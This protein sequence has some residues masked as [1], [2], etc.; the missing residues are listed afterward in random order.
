M[1]IEQPWDVRHIYT[2]ADLDFERYLNHLHE[3]LRKSKQAGWIQ[4]LHDCPV[5]QDSGI[6][7]TVQAS[8]WAELVI[9]DL[10]GWTVEQ[11]PWLGTTT[12]LPGMLLRDLPTDSWSASAIFLTG[13]RGGTP[14]FDAELD[15]ILTRR[16]TV[17]SHFDQAGFSDHTP[18]DLITAVLG[19][20]A[21]ADAGEV[22]NVVTSTLKARRP[23]AR[24]ELGEE[25]W[26]VGQRGPVIPR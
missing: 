3:K 14:E 2:T 6:S 1:T 15:R 16:T 10:H 7:R 23:Y 12:R 17:V 9:V 8:G 22:L 11:G 24:E 13:C 4:E 18:V 5:G 25:L 19:Q 21:G 26:T 20:T